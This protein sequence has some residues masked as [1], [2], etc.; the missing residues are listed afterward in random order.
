MGRHTLQ[1]L[2]LFAGWSVCA[3]AGPLTLTFTSPILTALPGQTVTFSATLKNTF[4]T[5][6]FLNADVANIAAPLTVDDTMFF[7]NTPPALAAGQS[8]TAPIL[9]I[10]IPAF[11]PL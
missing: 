1:Q 4:D 11:V 8:V 7:L 6:L 2:F 3:V 5:T 10:H 9:T